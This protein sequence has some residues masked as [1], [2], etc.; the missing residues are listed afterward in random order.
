V[1]KVN[2]QQ[3]TKS[4]PRP[5]LRKAYQYFENVKSEFQKIQ[6]TE[7]EEVRVFAKVVVVATFVLG[8]A[9]YLTDLCIQSMLGGLEH[10][11]MWFFG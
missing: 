7:G 11:L 5:S 8:M 2:L 10:I 6:W 1:E 3:K 4:M 9:L